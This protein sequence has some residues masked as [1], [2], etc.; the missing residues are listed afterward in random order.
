MNIQAREGVCH[1]AN[2]I[3]DRNLH[4]IHLERSF[5]RRS[6]RASH[7]IGPYTRTDHT[8]P[9]GTARLGRVVPGTSC[10]ATILQS[11]RDI[12]PVALTAPHAHGTALITYQTVSYTCG[13]A[14]LRACVPGV[15]TG[16]QSFT[17]RR[18]FRSPAHFATGSSFHRLEAIITP[19][20]FQRQR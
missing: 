20:T 12:L 5:V 3:I 2:C 8:V 19:V 13:A 18:L 7:R 15:R 6:H 1:G 4:N 16:L 10:Q 9:Y 14:T 17:T 11:L